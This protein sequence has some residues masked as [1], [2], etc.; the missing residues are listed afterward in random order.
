MSFSTINA[1]CLASYL[2][3]SV[4]QKNDNHIVGEIGYAKYDFN[5]ESGQLTINSIYDIPNNFV[6]KIEANYP[7]IREELKNVNIETAFGILGASA[8]K[9]CHKLL[10]A[11][12]STG[13]K[14]IAAS[15]FEN[16][17]SLF[18]VNLSSDTIGIHKNAFANTNLKEIFLPTTLTMIFA[19]SF[20]EKIWLNWFDSVGNMH[21]FRLKND[22]LAWFARHYT[23][24]VRGTGILDYTVTP[25][26]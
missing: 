4:E 26:V 21:R 13:I 14:T 2:A 9:N 11:T 5:P 7:L 19:N 10:S 12:I 24:E 17:T 20:N 25:F 22:T 3:T 6:D 15:A 16:C 1:F 23:C 18:Y 8:F